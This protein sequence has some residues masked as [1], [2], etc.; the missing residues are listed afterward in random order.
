MHQQTLWTAEVSTET[1]EKTVIDWDR[2]WNRPLAEKKKDRT[3][4]EKKK[5]QAYFSYLS[6]YNYL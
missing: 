4:L 2:L 1:R 6:F 5:E 3:E